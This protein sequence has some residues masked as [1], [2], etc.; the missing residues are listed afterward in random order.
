MC[1]S[2]SVSC[3][4]HTRLRRGAAAGRQARLAGEAGGAGWLRTGDLGFLWRGELYITGRIKDMI[5]VRGRNI[6]PNDLEDCLRASGHP[7]VRAA[8]APEGRRPHACM[9]SLCSGLQGCDRLDS[10]AACR[11][12]CQGFLTLQ[13]TR[14][15]RLSW[16]RA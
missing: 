10:R 13:A 5:I 12:P 7:L 2:L 1:A 4:K 14:E 8:A 11:G 16:T 15:Q 6:Y 3:K 9:S